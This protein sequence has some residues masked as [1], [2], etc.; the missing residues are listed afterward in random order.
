MFEIKQHKGA[1]S[2]CRYTLLLIFGSEEK[3]C[4]WREYVEAGVV[5]H[6]GKLMRFHQIQKISK[7]WR[8]QFVRDKTAQGDSKL[9]QI[10]III[11]ILELR[12]VVPMARIC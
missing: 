7:L 12:E 3:L 8:F 6:E 4:L 10:H 5:F 2:Y 1:Q 9:M 11:D